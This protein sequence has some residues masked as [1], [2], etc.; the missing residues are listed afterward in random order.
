MPLTDDE[1]LGLVMARHDGYVDNSS[2]RQVTGRHLMDVSRVLG[3]LRNRGLLRMIGANRGARYELGEADE[4]SRIEADTT[5][6]DIV[7]TE[8]YIES[9]EDSP[10]RSADSG[11]PSTE[12]SGQLTQR[13]LELLAQPIA[14][15]GRIDASQRDE[16][17]VQMCGLKPLSLFELSS[18]LSREPAYVRQVLRSLVATGKLRHEYPDRPQHPS[19]RYLA[20]DTEEQ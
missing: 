16:I 6:A 3:G 13:E 4:L 10:L 5:A 18:L 17:I 15:S 11:V 12:D 20:T 2:L 14:R 7:S 19:Q 1:Q 8:D 9:T